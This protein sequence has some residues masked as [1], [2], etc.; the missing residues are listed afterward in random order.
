M[1]IFALTMSLVSGCITTVGSPPKI[2]PIGFGDGSVRCCEIVWDTQ[3]S[4][5]MKCGPFLFE[6]VTNFVRLQGNCVRGAPE[7]KIEKGSEIL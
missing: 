4:I 3:Y 5:D 7:P 2:V 1:K 6:K